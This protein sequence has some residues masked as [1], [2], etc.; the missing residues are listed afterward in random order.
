MLKKL[1]YIFDKSSKITLVWLLLLI[2]IGS[3]FE[4]IGVTVFMP[5]IELIVD[6]ESLQTNSF[7]QNMFT[8]FPILSLQG[9]IAFVAI[10][11]I[12]FYI[13]KNIYLSFMQ[14]S[15]LNFSYKTR[16]RIATQLLATYMSEPYSFHL[17]KNAAE[18][19]RSLQIDANQFMLLLN[20]ALQFIAE[21]T[22]CIA[23]GL[24]LFHTSHSIT[25]IV[26]GLLIFCVGLYYEVSKKI[27]LRLGEQNQNYNSK[28]MQ[29]INQSLGGIKEVKVLER[30]E[31]FVSAY[32]ENY[33]KFPK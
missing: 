1:D 20:G 27:S 26:A 8:I 22:V 2:I 14:N 5:F 7:L 4:M 6:N 9:Q 13:V 32:K 17:N 29:W 11:I 31:Y 24:F 19:Q 3:F 12:I 15:I 23:I 16:M 21:I 28:L 30:E 25:V 18:L 33:K 10:L